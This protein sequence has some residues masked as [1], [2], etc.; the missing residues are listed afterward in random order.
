MFIILL[1]FYS[2]PYKMEIWNKIKSCLE[3][4]ILL[5]ALIIFATGFILI[6]TAIMLCIL[7]YVAIL[8]IVGK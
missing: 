4:P 5:M 1:A 3:L 7:G 2:I 6:A 8:K